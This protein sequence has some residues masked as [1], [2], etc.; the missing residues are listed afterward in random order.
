MT[1][2]KLQK[3]RVFGGDNVEFAWARDLALR[4]RDALMILLVSG[5]FIGIAYQSYIFYLIAIT[6]SLRQLLPKVHTLARTSTA[7]TSTDHATS[8]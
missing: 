5:M 3:M 4:L 8:T 1:L 7:G 2:L 6:I